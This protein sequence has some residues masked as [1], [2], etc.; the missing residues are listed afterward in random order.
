M[1]LRYY[2]MGVPDALIALGIITFWIALLWKTL[3]LIT[4]FDDNKELGSKNNVAYALQRIGLVSA[5]VLAMLAAM[6]D[7]DSSHRLASATWMMIEGAWI[8]AALLLSRAIVDWIVLPKI[9]N[10]SLLLEGNIA[11]GIVEAGAY[12]GLGYLLAG[13]LTGSASSNWLSFT[14]SVVFY[15]L[16]VALVAGVFWLHELVTPYSLRD[17]LKEGSV[18]AGLE[19]GGLLLAT[20]VVTSVGVAGDFIGWWIGIRAFLAT[21]AISIVL[22]YPGWIILNRFGPGQR[23]RDTQ[24][25]EGNVAAAAVSTSF[26]V[27]AGFLVASVVQTLL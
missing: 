10:T 19:T 24:K 23:E 22:L 25:Q 13:S 26:L 11:I 18:T 17:R 1:F 8:M 21:S 14:S 5:Q 20:S 4:K 12:I 6:S 2:A 3:N 7:F 27:L 15:A 9:N 16:G